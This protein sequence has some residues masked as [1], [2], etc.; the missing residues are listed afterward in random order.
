MQLSFSCWAY[1]SSPE[2]IEFHAEANEKLC[3]IMNVMVTDY[4]FQKAISPHTQMHFNSINQ[5]SSNHN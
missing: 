2:K 5:T 4:D 3:V 1:C